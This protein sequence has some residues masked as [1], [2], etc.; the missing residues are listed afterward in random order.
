MVGLVG[1]PRIRAMRLGCAHVRSALRT[2]PRAET[3]ARSVRAGQAGHPSRPRRRRKGKPDSF[4]PV[5]LDLRF[6]SAPSC[7]P[8][9]S[10]VLGHWRKG[11]SGAALDAISIVVGHRLGCAC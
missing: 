4:M 9:A 1:V 8:R 10:V 7:L 2:R 3:S 6:L 5:A 11:G